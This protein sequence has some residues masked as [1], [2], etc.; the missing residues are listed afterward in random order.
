MDRVVDTIFYWHVY[1]NA[2]IGVMVR[3][4]SSCD[5][6]IDFTIESMEQLDNLVC[7][8]CGAHVDKNA[9]SPKQIAYKQESDEQEEKTGRILMNIFYLPYILYVFFAIFGIAFYFLNWDKALIVATVIGV[10]SCFARRVYTT[11]CATIIII[12]AGFGY[13]FY[14]DISITCLCVCIGLIVIFIIRRIIA[15]LWG[16]FI[17]WS[18]KQ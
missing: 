11:M 4:C 15:R 9:K 12:S 2:G 6:S 18:A 8:N 10:L 7:P 5:T 13:Y 3:Y 16:A 14:R 1:G 17:R